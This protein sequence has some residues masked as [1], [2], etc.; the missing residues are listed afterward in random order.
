M[1]YIERKRKLSKKSK[2]KELKRR[3][4]RK[5]L[6]TAEFFSGDVPL[7]KQGVV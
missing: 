3:F 7:W 2:R 4:I 5:N 1:S 6:S